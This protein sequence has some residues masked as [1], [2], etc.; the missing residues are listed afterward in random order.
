MA[1]TLDCSERT[2]ATL[3]QADPQTAFC[4]SYKKGDRNAR[5][6]LRRE[7][8]RLALKGDRTMLIWLGKQRLGQHDQVDVASNMSGQQ[9]IRIEIVHVQSSTAEPRFDFVLTPNGKR[10]GADLPD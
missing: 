1:Y 3:M 8:Q 2:I 4:I 10:D 6:S 7:Q 5:A 9:T